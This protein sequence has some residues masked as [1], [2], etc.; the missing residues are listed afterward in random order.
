MLTREGL[1]GEH[2]AILPNLYLTDGNGRNYDHT[3]DADVDASSGCRVVD[4]GYVGDTLNRHV[5][6][7]FIKIGG[8]HTSGGGRMFVISHD[9]GLPIKVWLD[10]IESVE[11][12]C[13]TQAKNLSE[14]PFI[15]RHVALMP[16]THEGYGM[17]I[18]GVI[19]CKDVIIPNA[20]G[21]DIGCGMA[22]AATDIQAEDFYPYSSSVVNKIM[23][24]IPVGFNHH[25][26]PQ[27][28]VSIKSASG[29]D[30]V[31]ELIPELQRGLF[32]VGTLGG[33]NHFIELQ[34]DTKRGTV[35]IMIHSGS[36]NFGLK[37]AKL[38][39]NK[40]KELNV[41]WFST[42]PS[43]HDL[44]FLPVS[45]DEGKSYLWWMNLALSFARESRSRM[46]DAVKGIIYKYTGTID[47]RDE[48]DVHHN[49]AAIENHFGKDVWVHRKGAIRSRENEIGIIP[50]SMGSYSYIVRGK[51]NREAFQSCSHGAGRKMSRKRARELFPAGKVMSD[52]S[53]Q[54]VVVGVPDPTTVGDE[55]SG[56]YKDIRYVIEQ[57]ADLAE[58]VTELRTIAVVKG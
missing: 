6:G 14:L 5:T 51:G 15:L 16:D 2:I 50:G 43:E 25:K 56:A 29:R 27:P 21:V 9:K 33:G 31:R 55:C 53:A 23:E 40:A 52:L 49:Y 37:I 11:E 45:S 41:E 10:S 4:R 47:Y 46:M 32:Q 18:G 24:Q 35:S 20:V 26:D 13:L 1:H 48:C 42:V 54:G 12:G 19:A 7:T 58:V 44:A 36:R 30:D 57:E 38:F 34:E 17:P 22:Y 3:T 39:N 28:C 8:D